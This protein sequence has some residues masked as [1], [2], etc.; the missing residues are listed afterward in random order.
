MPPPLVLINA[1]GLTPRLLPHAPRLAKLAA[2]GMGVVAPG[3]VAGRHLYGPGD[4]ADRQD[5]P[6][7]SRRRRQRLAV[8]GHPWKSASGS[9]RTGSSRPNRC[10]SPRGDG[11]RARGRDCF[12]HGQAVLVVQPGG[13]GRPERHPEAVVRGR[14]RTRRSACD[15]HARPAFADDRLE[16]E[17]GPFPFPVVLGADGRAGVYRVDGPG[18]PP[19]RCSARPI[20]PDARRTCPTSTTS[21]SAAAR[22]AATCRSWSANWTPPVP[23]CSTP[24]KSAGARVWVVSEYGHCDVTT[25]GPPRTGFSAEVGLSQRYGRVRSARDLTPFNSRAFA[26]CDHQL[27]HIYVVRPR[28]PAASSRRSLRPAEVGVS[29]VM[30]KVSRT[31]RAWAGSLARSG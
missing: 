30:A 28:R 19:P 24:P 4:A 11:R 29:R 5:T 7:S 17:L 26:V 12:Q 3:G 6:S 22:P 16:A 10:T 8:P 20:R 14:R 13:G 2:G 31:R 23:R 25:R 1:V 27:A 9:S 15:R 18:R 21:P